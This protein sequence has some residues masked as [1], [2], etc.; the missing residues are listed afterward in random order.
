M[1]TDGSNP[2]NVIKEKQALVRCLLCYFECFEFLITPAAV[3]VECH[4]PSA[5]VAA[6][7]FAAADSEDVVAAVASV[8]VVLAAADAD[9]AD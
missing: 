9:P 7:A 1:A 8:P 5:A 6:L 4:C 3:Q 2:R